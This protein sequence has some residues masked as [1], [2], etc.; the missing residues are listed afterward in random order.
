MT[1][2]NHD[3]DEGRTCPASQAKVAKVKTRYWGL[4]PEFPNT[5]RE[6]MRR[7]A[8]GMVVAITSVLWL[9]YVAYVIWWAYA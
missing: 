7:L 1:C 4:E 5:W 9:L 8:F 6:I 3:C 2:C